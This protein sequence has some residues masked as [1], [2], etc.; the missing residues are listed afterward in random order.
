MGKKLK[1]QSPKTLLEWQQSPLTL[2]EVQPAWCRHPM[3]EKKSLKCSKEI[4]RV[5]YFDPVSIY[6]RLEEK[7]LL[8]P[9]QRNCKI[10]RAHV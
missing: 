3:I 5:L 9:F 10:G 4:L 8:N 1:N 6:Q 7:K 2:S